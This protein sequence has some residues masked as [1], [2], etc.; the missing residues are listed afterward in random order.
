MDPNDELPSDSDASDGDYCPEAD[1][2]HKNVS[3]E[4]SGKEDD[5]EPNSGEDV[6]KSKQSKKKLKPGMRKRRKPATN[7]S[8][9]SLKIENGKAEEKRV[10]DSSESTSENEED[11]KKK[12]DALWADFLNDT[13]PAVPTKVETKKTVVLEKE[14]EN[15]DKKVVEPTIEKVVKVFEYAGETVTTVVEELK[16]ETPVRLKPTMNV[17]KTPATS[18]A[19]GKFVSTPRPKVGGGLGSILSQLGKKNKISTLEKTKLDWDGFKRNEGLDEELQT[20][21]KGK[22]G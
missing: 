22:D 10:K 12:S 15:H 9:K 1:S 13:E 4:E 2:D 21:N 17:D 20:H 5:E 18:S 19:L 16:I 3:E 11:D 6:T 7:R 14:K 8:R